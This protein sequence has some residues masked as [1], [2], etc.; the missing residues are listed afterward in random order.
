M[1]ATLRYTLPDEEYEHQ[2]AMEGQKARCVL[3]DLAEAIR[4]RLKFGFDGA[5]KTPEQAYEDIR[6]VLYDACDGQSI[7]LD[8]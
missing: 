1:I 4:S 7:S 5:I 3:H 8:W 2:A 6:A